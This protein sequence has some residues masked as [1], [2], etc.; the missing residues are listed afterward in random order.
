MKSNIE[1]F[2]YV[3]YHTKHSV[4]INNVYLSLSYDIINPVES[5]RDLGVIM[6]NSCSFNAHIAKTVLNCSCL[7]SWILCTFSKRDKCTMLTLFKAV[8][9]SVLEYACQLWSPGTVNLITK[10]EKMQRSFTKYIFNMYELTYENRLKD[11]NLYFI[12]R[13]KDRYQINYVW[14]ILKEKVTNLNSP[15]VTNSSGRLGRL[16]IKKHVTSDRIGSI[17]H[18]SFRWRAI[19]LFNSLPKSVRNIRDV[20][21]SVFNRSLDYFLRT[22]RDSPTEL[23]VI[24]KSHWC[25]R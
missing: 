24:A 12:Q 15:T 22:L 1:K 13:K 4:N 9:R 8:V 16:C 25:Q 18:N 19:R 6:A 3:C 5:L 7:I 10:L 2:Q 21:I 11:L 14:K 20:D 23:G 17:A